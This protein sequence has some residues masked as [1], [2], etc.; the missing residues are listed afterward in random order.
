M[1]L[2]ILGFGVLEI[3][4][5]WATEPEEE[6]QYPVLCDDTHYGDPE[7]DLRAMTDMLL[8]ELNKLHAIKIVRLATKWGL[9]DAKKFVDKRLA[10]LMD[11]H[12]YVSSGPSLG[13]YKYLELLR[14]AHGFRF[15]QDTDLD[16]KGFTR[17]D[18]E[19]LD[20]AILTNSKQDVVRTSTLIPSVYRGR[21]KTTVV[22]MSERLYETRRDILS[23]FGLA[24]RGEDCAVR[25]QLYLEHLRDLKIRREMGV[26]EENADGRESCSTV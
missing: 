18:M 22:N 5:T 26:V 6:S 24:F 10:A 17:A 7:Y 4:W 12:Y 16:F 25:R 20:Q 23:T 19:H 14:N 2:S 15:I 3:N 8:V 11:A 21:S 13:G 1:K 9:A